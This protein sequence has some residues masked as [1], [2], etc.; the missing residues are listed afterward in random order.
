LTQGLARRLPGKQLLIV[1]NTADDFEHLGMKIS[2]D[3]DTVMYWLAE[4]NDAERG[5]GIASETWNFMSALERLGGATW[6]RLGDRD[7]AT[8]VQRTQ[9]LSH[10]STLSEATR[11]LCRRLGVGHQ[12]APMS[13][14]A[15]ATIV[16]TVDGVLPFQEYFVRR[17][18]QPVIKG[19]FFEGIDTAAPSP[20]FR[21][22]MSD[23][24]L[25]AVIICP[26]NPYLSIDP[27][28][29][30]PTVR[31]WL[32]NRTF[33]A[34]AVSP[35]VGGKAVKG[36]ADKIMNELGH[37]VSALGIAKHYHGLIDVLVIDDAD[38]RLAPGI[39]A[40]ETRA[41]ITSTIMKTA[42]DRDRL[43]ESVLTFVSS[44]SK[45]PYA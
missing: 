33:P 6:F 12:I 15:V 3:L 1:V 8:H 42:D 14:Q 39:E 2:P 21:A 40:L 29:S 24:A 20:A 13:D 9:L 16:R 32:S 10:G 30:L 18:C 38:E 28:L 22:A 45:I 34:I 23:R 44:S 37:D 36:P 5:W 25:T 7:V 17:Q 35:I 43:A 26:S 4:M 31:D 11:Q 27:I 41:L 19:I